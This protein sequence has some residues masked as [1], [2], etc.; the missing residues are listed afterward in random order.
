VDFAVIGLII[1]P[2][3]SLSLG[4]Y[5]FQQFCPVHGGCH[6]EEGKYSEWKA[7]LSSERGFIVIFRTLDAWQLH[8]HWYGFCGFLG[9]SYLILRECSPQPRLNFTELCPPPQLGLQFSS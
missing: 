3:S 7:Q 5:L 8:L 1:S 4:D 6:E 9:S 2:Q